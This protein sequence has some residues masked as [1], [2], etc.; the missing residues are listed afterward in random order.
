MADDFKGYFKYMSEAV[1][2]RS[3]NKF[4]AF[5]DADAAIWHKDEKD[6]YHWWYFDALSDDGSEAVRISFMTGLTPEFLFDKN[7][8]NALKNQVDQNIRPQIAFTFFCG[9]KVKYSV[10]CEL[11]SNEFNADEKRSTCNFGAS[12]FEFEAAEYGSGHSIAIN[13]PL[14]A[15]H[16]I[17]AHFEWLWIESDLDANFGSQNSDHTWNVV[18]PRSDVTGRITVLNEHNKAIEVFHFRGTGYYDQRIGI[19]PLIGNIS[20]WQFGRAHFNDTTI[21]FCSYKTTEMNDQETKLMIVKDG[22]LKWHDMTSSCGK[23]KRGASGAYF[24]E[25]ISF[26]NDNGLTLLIKPRHT[27]SI[28]PASVSLLCDMTLDQGNDIRS[29]NTGLLEIIKINKPKFR[30]LSW[31]RSGK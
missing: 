3:I 29:M 2:S 22:V 18:A 12:K 5:S 16:N 4:S 15:S 27:A 24:P 28:N 1:S 21:A 11:N 8:R 14:N 26:E 30:L 7:K 31:F 17:E 9:G 25:T 13:L 10:N 23:T 19:T 6:K 20:E